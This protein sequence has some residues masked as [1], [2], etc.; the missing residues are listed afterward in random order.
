MID[1]MS[2]QYLRR[3]VNGD[4]KIET[5][6]NFWFADDCSVDGIPMPRKTANEQGAWLASPDGW[7]AGWLEVHAVGAKA[8]ADR[9][10]RVAAVWVNTHGPHGHIARLVPNP[11]GED[12]NIAQAGST[13]FA[14]GPLAAGFGSRPVRFFT[15]K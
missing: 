11:T 12:I 4:G 14:R 10:E 6:C 5:F 15:H 1:P 3:D 7:H 13:N 2:A 9:G 8:A